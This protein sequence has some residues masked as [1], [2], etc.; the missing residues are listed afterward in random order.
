MANSPLEDSNHLMESQDWLH[1][2]DFPLS[3][4]LQAVNL[5]AIKRDKTRLMSVCMNQS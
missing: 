3:F 4:S 5:N 1:I 2:S